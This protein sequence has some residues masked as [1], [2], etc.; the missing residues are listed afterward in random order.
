MELYTDG[1][2]ILKNPSVYGGTYGFVIVKSGKEIY[3]GSGTYSPEEMGT[4]TVTN[5]QMELIAVLLGLQYAD[6]ARHKI[7]KI[8][9]DSQITLGRLFNSWRLKNIPDW[10]I[11]MKDSLSLRGIKGEFQRG[12]SGHKWN[13]LADGLAEREATEFLRTA[14]LSHLIYQH[15]NPFW[16]R[17]KT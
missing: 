12:H 3:R 14:G 6:S 11:E 1:G 10:M 5:N 4:S 13:E 8:V 16:K 15:K 7:T 2:V 17:A 9:S